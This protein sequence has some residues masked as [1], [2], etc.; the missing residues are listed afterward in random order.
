MHILK[1]RNI[2]AFRFNLDLFNFYKFTWEGDFFRIEDP[3]AGT[4]CRYGYKG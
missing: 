1:K 2:P 3:V 4:V